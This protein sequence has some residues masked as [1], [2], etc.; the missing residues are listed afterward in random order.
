MASVT[1]AVKFVVKLDGHAKL[2]D[3][4]GQTFFLIKTEAFSLKIEKS[5]VVS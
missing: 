3:E 2:I 4:P 1:K 5:L